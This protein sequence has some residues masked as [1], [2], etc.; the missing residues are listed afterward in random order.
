MR[1]S[2]ANASVSSVGG[3]RE[4]GWCDYY[5]DCDT[6]PLDNPINCNKV[7]S[8]FYS[9]PRIDSIFP[10]SIVCV[11]HSLFDKSIIGRESPLLDTVIVCV[12]V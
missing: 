9:P 3:E 4:R 6:L 2:V 12:C 10:S 8:L 1:E 7:S 11:F 5:S